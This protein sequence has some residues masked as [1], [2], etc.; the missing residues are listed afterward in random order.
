MTKRYND[1]LVET[2]EE[3]F[4]KNYIKTLDMLVKAENFKRDPYVSDAFALINVLPE[5]SEKAELMTRWENISKAV[6]QE[7]DQKAL[8]KA[9]QYVEY[10]ERFKSAFLH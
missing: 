8:K 6:Q 3:N 2:E 4:Q 5:R 10:A 1:L 7:V 9:T